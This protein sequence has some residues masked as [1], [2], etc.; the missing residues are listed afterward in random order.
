[1]PVKI[2]IGDS[3]KEVAAV[4]INI[5]DTWK[6]VVDMP[7]NIGDSWKVGNLI[8]PEAPTVTTTSVTSI[9]GTTATSGGNVTSD[10]N[11]PVTDRGICWSTSQNPT[12]SDSHT[13]DSSGTGVFTSSLISLTKGT[14]YYVRAYAINAIGTSYGSQ[15]SFTSLIEPTVIT[16]AESSVAETTATS[17]GNVTS[18]GGTTVTDRGVCWNTSGSPTTSDS[19]T[20]DSSGTGSF[21]SSITGLTGSTTYHVRAYAINSVGTSY[22]AEDDFT[23]SAPS[24]SIGDAHQGGV[25]FYITA[26][27]A[28]QSS[29]TNG[30]ICKTSDMTSRQWGCYGSAISGANGATIGTG[31]QNTID[32]VNGCATRPIAASDCYD[33]NDGTYSDW[34]LPSIDELSQ[35][36]VQ[37]TAIG[38]TW[39]SSRY[40]A[41]TEG[42]GTNYGAKAVYMP[43]GAVS[44]GYGRDNS[45]PFRPIRNF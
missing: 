16:T 3:W 12:V 23:T 17:G 8:V 30:L 15:Q 22:G 38:D 34:Y 36:Y 28:G 2:N 37:K 19:H 44:L 45:L 6:D 41:S 29:G 9:T 35:V 24:K 4:K 20:H 42:D 14:L 1:M 27:V 13:H 5:G 32:V 39:A 33:Y 31:N 25:V 26:P 18:D 7:I 40:W 21:S 43:T 10:G 11:S